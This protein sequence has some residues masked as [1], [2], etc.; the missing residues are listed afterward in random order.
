M[1]KKKKVFL[2]AGIGIAVI[3]TVFVLLLFLDGGTQLFVT[4]NRRNG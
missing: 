1:R 2:S 3:L 4:V